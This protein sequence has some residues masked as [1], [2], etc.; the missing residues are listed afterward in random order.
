MIN[1]FRHKKKEKPKSEILSSTDLTQ[2]EVVTD[3]TKK[4]ILDNSR[5]EAS[6]ILFH[7]NFSLIVCAFTVIMLST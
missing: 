1:I 6:F 7:F 5:W 4:L 3:D 2:T